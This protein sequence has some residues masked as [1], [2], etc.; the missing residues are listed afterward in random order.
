MPDYRWDPTG[1]RFRDAETGR[2]VSF[3]RVRSVQEELITSSRAYISGVAEQVSAGEISTDA[4]AAVMKQEIKDEYIRQAMLGR[5]GYL[6]MTPSD[7][8]KVG[9]QIKEQYKYLRGFIDEVAAGKVP[10]GMVD[11]RA[12]MYINSAREAF[13]TANQKVQTEAGFDLEHWDLDSSVENCPSCQEFAA[14]GWVKIEDDPYNGAFPG[15]GNTEC[16]TSCHC[17]ISYMKSEEA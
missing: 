4:W 9:S 13:E 14:M 15:S 2:F 5:G 1:H 7:W 6:Q 17:S 10:P 16:K 12:Q 8:G 3:T 11:M